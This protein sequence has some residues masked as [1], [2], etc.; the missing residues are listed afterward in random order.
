MQFSK[1]ILEAIFPTRQKRFLMVNVLEKNLEVLK[2]SDTES[3][4]ELEN[5]RAYKVLFKYEEDEDN[6]LLVFWKN[7]FNV[8]TISVSHKMF[9]NILNVLVDGNRIFPSIYRLTNDFM[10][11]F[12][13]YSS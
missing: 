13:F 6:P 2:S 11:S 5:C 4:F 1:V 8:H 9:T 10:T 3:A 7:D 12:I